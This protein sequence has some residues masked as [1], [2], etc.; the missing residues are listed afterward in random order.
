MSVIELRVDHPGGEDFC[1]WLQL[2]G[3]DAAVGCS[4]QTYVDD[5][6]AEVSDLYEEFCND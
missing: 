1:D 4:E 5:E 2:K 3:H 6:P